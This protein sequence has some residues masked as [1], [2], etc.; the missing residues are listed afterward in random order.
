[1]SAVLLENLKKAW[2]VRYPTGIVC[3]RFRF[4]FFPVPKAASTSIKRLIAQMDGLPSEGDPHHDIAFELAWGKDLQKYPGYR[5]FTAVRNPWDRLVSCFK[6][7]IRS[8]YDPR[9]GTRPGIH[10]GLDRYNKILGRQIFYEDMSF[11]DFVD[12][13][14]KIP[15]SLADEHI[16]S[17]YRMFSTSGGRLLAEHIIHFENLYAELTSLFKELGI[18]GF[19]IEHLNK[20][21]GGEYRRFYTDDLAAAVGKVYEKDVKLLGYTF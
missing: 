15:D 9:F 20:S 7:K 8:G 6:D 12:V 18:E 2:R 1:M 11:A 17:Q 19:S 16:R 5:T 10:E 3:H 21:T 13:I 14:A 4:I